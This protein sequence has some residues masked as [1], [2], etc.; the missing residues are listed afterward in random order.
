MN[1]IIL[2]TAINFI[3]GLNMIFSQGINFFE[4]SWDE[5]L[6]QAKA[7]NKIIFVDSYTK[8]C[9]PCK[10]LQTNIFPTDEAG[11]FYN[12]NFINF[13]IDMESQSGLEFGVT[14]PVRAY[15]TLF[16]IDS[17][18]KIINSHVGGTDVDG[19]INLGKQA[20]SNFDNSVDLEK[21]W[22][23]GNRDYDFVLNY[24]KA[25][26]SS[27]KST[28]KITN[29]Y[30]SEKPDISKDQK[31]V[32]IFEAVYDSDSK[33]FDKMVSNDYMKNI[34]EIYSEKE[35]SDKIYNAC[36]K[37]IEK[38]YEYDVMS[39]QEDAKN[40]MKK[41]DKKR[42]SE[43]CTKLD[44]YNSENNGDFQ[45]YS[46]SAIKYINDLS[47]DKDKI[48]FIQNAGENF[49]YSENIAEFKESLIKSA[50]KSKETTELSAYYVKFL[51]E[52]NKVN[53]SREQYAKALK[54]ATKM[55]DQETIRTLKRYELFLQN[56]N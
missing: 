23:K 47:N 9:G 24:I 2:I 21:E 43:F 53:E 48:E 37:T 22:D 36:W 54:L 35:I 46:K 12:K 15:P 31:A 29:D 8:W 18:G 20:L 41:Y 13:K 33:L 16:Y 3:V 27:K 52:N 19:L 17:N 40:K 38:S 44:L 1:R 50:L 6:S 26:N 30:L 39:L 7:Q 49:K 34:K 11:A 45:S 42:Y 14:Y 32:L 25:L 10:R 4:G 51:I 55:D 28:I 56:S 5:A